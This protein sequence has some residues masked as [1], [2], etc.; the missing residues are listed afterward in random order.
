MEI[1]F[2]LICP[3]LHIISFLVQGGTNAS[4]IRYSYIFEPNVGREARQ[5]FSDLASSYP[6]PMERT[7]TF[8]AAQ[9]HT[10]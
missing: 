3:C 6:S 1:Q 9:A 4:M 7:S 2:D 5:M 10:S 8:S